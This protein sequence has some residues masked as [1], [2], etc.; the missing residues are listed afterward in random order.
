M[1][2]CFL[3]YLYPRAR[4]HSRSNPM[5]CFLQSNVLFSVWMSCFLSSYFGKQIQLVTKCSQLRVPFP[6][7][8]MTGL[9]RCCSDGVPY[10]AHLHTHQPAHKPNSIRSIPDPHAHSIRAYTRWVSRPMRIFYVRVAHTP[11]FIFAYRIQFH[12]NALQRNLCISVKYALPN[13]VRLRNVTKLIELAR[14]L[15]WQGH[16]RPYQIIPNR[17][18]TVG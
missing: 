5:S 11:I 12:W 18:W 6:C 15:F 9:R 4:P 8:E 16:L 14:G 13:R 7:T 1:Y 10:L 2:L 17:V 3:I